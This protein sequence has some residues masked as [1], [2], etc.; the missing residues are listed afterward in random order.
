MRFD[1]II[2]TF[3]LKKCRPGHEWPSHCENIRILLLILRSAI[4][5]FTKM[6]LS[7]EE[8]KYLS[9]RIRNRDGNALH[10]LYVEMFDALQRYAYRYVYDW[11]EAKDIVQTAFLQLWLN[12]EKVDADGDIRSYLGG[13]VHNLCSNFLRHLNIIDE[14]QEKLTEALV[15]QNLMTEKDNISPEMKARLKEALD[16]LPEKGRDI[17]MLHVVE[18]MKC[19]DIAGRFGVAESTVKTHLKRAMKV[20]RE[21][22]LLIIFS[23]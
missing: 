18:G 8:K 17:L 14:N 10:T 22:M 2:C 1:T 20:L 12:A 7:K 3:L 9:Q 21:H 19:S 16:A 13:I 15:F 4:Y 23:L 5:A 6:S 11:E